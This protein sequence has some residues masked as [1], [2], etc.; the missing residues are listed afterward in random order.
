MQ[1]FHITF[2]LDEEQF[3]ETSAT[4]VIEN[5]GAEV[6]AIFFISNPGREFLF[7]GGYRA[8]KQRQRHKNSSSQ[9]QLRYVVRFIDCR[10]HCFFL[11]LPS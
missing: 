2:K 3:T 5:Q 10:F 7:I 11:L 1:L 8:G 9:L 6:C 4:R